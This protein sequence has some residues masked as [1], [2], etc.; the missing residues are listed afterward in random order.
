MP[1]HV[2]ITRRVL[3]G[4][5]AEFQNELRE[6][7]QTSFGHGS[8]LGASMLTPPPGSDSREYGILRTFTNE[9]D[10]DAFYR[11]PMFKAWDERAR[12]LTE[13]EPEYRQMHGLEAWFRSPSNPPPRWKMAVTTALGVYPTSLFLGETVGRLT[14]ELPLLLRSAV[15]AIS[16]VILLTWVVMPLVTRILHTWL[17]PETES[18]K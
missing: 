3:P 17:H 13:D 6:F 1:I 16:M 14:H 9:A 18:K 2:A 5:E 12:V 10:R 8:V 7:F 11:T 4:H 15:F